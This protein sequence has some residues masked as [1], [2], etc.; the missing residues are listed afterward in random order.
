MVLLKSILTGLGA[1]FLAACLVGLWVQGVQYRLAMSAAAG[2]S[3]VVDVRWHKGPVI[4]SLL[5]VFAVGFAW[6]YRKGR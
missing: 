5:L 1:A 6:Q 3:A 4:L 2:D